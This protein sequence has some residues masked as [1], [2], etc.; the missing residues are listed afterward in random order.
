VPLIHFSKDTLIVTDKGAFPIK[1]LVG[2]TVNIWNGNSW[3]T[4][5][6][7][8]KTGANQPMLKIGLY[9][10]SELRVTPY[11]TMKVEDDIGGINDIPAKDLNIGMKLQPSEATYNGNIREYGA[12]LKGFMLGDGE[13]ENGA[14]PYLKLYPPKYDCEA[15][16]IDSAY[17]LEVE[18]KTLILTLKTELAFELN[19]DMTSKH[20]EGLAACK[21]ELNPWV[22]TY[23]E[24]L[25]YE[26]FQWNHDSKCKFIA[27]YFDADGSAVDNQ[28][29]GYQATSINRSILAGVQILLKSIGVRSH[30]A[31]GKKADIKAMPGG[32]YYCQPLWRLSIA[33]ESSIKLAQQVR[34][35]RLTSFANRS[36]LNTRKSK[37]GKIVSIQNDGIDAEVF[38]CTVPSNH[39]ISLSIG[40]SAGNCGEANLPTFGAE[41]LVGDIGLSRVRSIDDAKR[42][43]FLLAKCL[44]RVAG[45]M[46][47][48]NKAENARSMRI[49]VSVIGFFEFFW[50]HFGLTFYD[51]ISVHDF[52]FGKNNITT[53]N[54]MSIY[55]MPSVL[56]E[57]QTEAV[58]AWCVLRDIA[59][60]AEIGAIEEADKFGFNHPDTTLV[61][62]P[63]GTVAKV[64]AA[65]ESA[66]PPSRSTY[67]RYIQFPKSVINDGVELPNPI[68]TEYSKCGYVI[69][70]ISHKYPGYVVVGF[71]TIQPY[72]LALR[73]AGVPEDQIVK[74][75]KLSMEDNYKWLRLLEKFWLGSNPSDEGAPLNGQI[76]YTMKVNFNEVSFD[77]FMKAIAENQPTIRCCSYN[78]CVNDDQAREEADN[79]A[80]VYGYSPEYP[81]DWTEYTSLM[82][83]ITPANKE[84]YNENEGACEGNF[85]ALDGNVN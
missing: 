60:Q 84:A 64:L 48:I 18:A 56:N 51:M 52:I 83:N 58:R 44:V 81:I 17:E 59:E 61:S 72:V 33:Q 70:D 2:K 82:A 47:G 55:S 67:L 74:A 75:N 66:N 11:H 42:S 63:G 35:S 46:P 1:S 34:F 24:S 40:V 50:N 62:K 27:G 76:A 39:T 53:P 43:A 20:L 80:E 68:V 12:Y 85:C 19:S 57:K 49:G 28:E 30:L 45:I 38:C 7:F 6:T 71:P 41:C 13:L 65:T 36:I 78:P 79:L 29:F 25:P 15:R 14:R 21:T 69:K 4:I 73:E 16:L 77:Q 9:D 37:A 31:L 10:G 32:E 8:R 23:R 26:V 54:G 3:E 5:N 22:S